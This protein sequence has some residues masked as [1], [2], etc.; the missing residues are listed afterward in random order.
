M[1]FISLKRIIRSG[2]IYLIRQGGL[3]VATI[4]TMV[5]VIS[6]ITSLFLFREVTRFS[7]A[8]LQEKVDVSVY[9]KNESTEKDIL[10]I[11]DEISKLP[12]VKEVEYISNEEAKKRLL[13]R[14]PKLKESLTETEGMLN[15]ASLNI[16]AATGEQ[17]S[18]IV[19]FLENAY[20]KDLIKEIDYL[21]RKPIIEKIFSIT[22]IINRVGFIF[23]LILG[24]VSFLLAFNQIKLAIHNS[25]EEIFIQRLVGASNWFIR[26]P[27]LIQGIISGFFA[28]LIVALFFL[29]LIYFLSPKIESFFTGLNL[30]EYYRTN[31]G[32]L[33]LIQVLSGVGLGLF[34][35]YIAMRKYLQI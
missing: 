7:I 14:K 10:K 31:F 22:S 18:A 3:T 29:P 23:S 26:G 32:Y 15:L 13:E 33:L 16:K 4:F 25:C 24:G 30:F 12:E 17:Y 8:L 19:N 34:S 21:E 28:A 5:M 35:S 9:F 6:L 11:K 2:W 27:F 20:F 1:I